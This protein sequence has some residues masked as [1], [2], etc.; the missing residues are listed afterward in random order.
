MVE[1]LTWLSHFCRIKKLFG[2]LE[3]LSHLRRIHL[4]NHKVVEALYIGFVHLQLPCGFVLILRNVYY[5]AGGANII[6]LGSMEHTNVDFQAHNSIITLLHEDR[7]VAKVNQMSKIWVLTAEKAV[8]PDM[9][10]CL[11]NENTLQTRPV[12]TERSSAVQVQLDTIPGGVFAL[13]GCAVV[14]H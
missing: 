8:A 7:V 4:G 9:N 12:Q 13:S 11:H 3:R 5:I 10:L 6:S 14:M 1:L 2:Q